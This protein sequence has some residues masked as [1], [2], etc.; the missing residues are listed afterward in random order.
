MFNTQGAMCVFTMD[1]A[2]NEQLNSRQGNHLAC[3]KA[4][5]LRKW[6][7]LSFIMSQSINNLISGIKDIY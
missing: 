6:M 2:Y 3:R 1:P 4:V 7:A 5:V